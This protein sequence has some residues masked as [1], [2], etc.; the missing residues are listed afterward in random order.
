MEIKRQHTAISRK[1]PN[2]PVLWALEQSLVVNQ[3]YDWGCGRGFDV[4]YINSLKGYVAYGYD[5]YWNRENHPDVFDHW[6]RI[7]TIFCN[8]VLNVI[9]DREERYEVLGQI[10]SKMFLNEC[11][12][13]ILTLRNNDVKKYAEKNNWVKHKDGFVTSKNTFQKG[14]SVRSAKNLCKR[15]AFRIEWVEKISGGIILLLSE[16]RAKRSTI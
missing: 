5:P 6:W 2:V 12:H 9:E 7:N 3:V 16:K 15:S 1:K 4:D 11:R 10:R 13:L 8:Y 14:Y